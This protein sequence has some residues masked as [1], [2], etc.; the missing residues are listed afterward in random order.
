MAMHQKLDAIN[1]INQYVFD[2]MATAISVDQLANLVGLS[3]YHLHRIFAAQT[4]FEIAEYIQRR[5]M[6]TALSLLKQG[7]RSVIDV[8][9]E[10]GYESHSSFSRVFKKTFGIAPSQSSQQQLDSALI[11][12]KKSNKDIDE[13]IETRWLSLPERI[14]YGCY[15]KAFEKQ[16][17]ANIA[18]E[19]FNYLTD[20]SEQKDYLLSRPVGVS[21][22]NPWV[23]D[24][25]SSDFF[26]GFLSGLDEQ[27]QLTQLVW[28]K[29]NYIYT[30]YVGPYQGMWQ[31]ISKL[32]SIWASEKKIK[33]TVRK[34]YQRYLNSPQNTPPEHLKTEL[35]FPVEEIL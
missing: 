31:F 13:Y 18:T 9:L 8:A 15:C 14:L 12:Y 20:L 28:P 11:L 22:N 35:Y 29:G 17:F 32:H 5:K 6:E 4:G 30:E 21:L 25:Q 26:C 27:T 23:N 3:K 16:S 7:N 2:N 19:N 1:Q 33:L 10:V 34:V 24:S